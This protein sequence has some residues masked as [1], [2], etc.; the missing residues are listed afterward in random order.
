[1]SA[2]EML[3]EMKRRQEQGKA[4]S[5]RRVG[6]FPPPQGGMES[7]PQIG[8]NADISTSNNTQLNMKI[9]TPGRAQSSSLSDQ[10]SVHLVKVIEVINSGGPTGTGEFGANKSTSRKHPVQKCN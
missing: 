5:I 2:K 10:S 1:M 3:M 6:P 9:S 7:P 8:L 4:Q